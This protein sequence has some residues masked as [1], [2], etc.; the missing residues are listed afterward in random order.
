MKSAPQEMK[1][2]E[3]MSD[4]T[5]QP[6]DLI[7]AATARC[8]CGAGLAYRRVLKRDD[9]HT[10]ECSVRL[11]CLPGVTSVNP[12]HSGPL[13]DEPK[14]FAFYEIKSEGQPSAGGMT[15]RRVPLSPLELAEIEE[16]RRRAVLAS[17]LRKLTE[18]DRN[19][20]TAESDL[21][22]AQAAV[23]ALKSSDSAA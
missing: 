23:A 14:P 20:A 8:S 13:H 11:L 5:L 19:H 9:E 6:K 7:F 2:N 10:W 1:G 17:A 21:M 15:T 16:D 3:T 4:G 12:L 22:D 18:A